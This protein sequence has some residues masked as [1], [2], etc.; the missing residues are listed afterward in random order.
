M[1]NCYKDAILEKYSEMNHNNIKQP[2]E[3][4]NIHVEDRCITNYDNITNSNNNDDTMKMK[5][6]IEKINNKDLLI[7]SLLEY[8]L[9]TNANYAQKIFMPAKNNN[10]TNNHWIILINICKYL[11]NIGIIDNDS[12][13]KTDTSHLRS[14]YINFMNSIINK[15]SIN[16]VTT[17]D[18]NNTI[19][20]PHRDIIKSVQNN[21]S[22]IV[23]TTDITNNTNRKCIRSDEYFNINDKK[24]ITNKRDIARQI[25]IKQLTQNYEFPPSSFEKSDESRN[26]G[27]HQRGALSRSYYPAQRCNEIMG[28]KCDEYLKSICIR[29][30]GTIVK[31][32]DQLNQSNQ[33]NQLD[34]LTQSVPTKLNNDIIIPNNYKINDTLIIDPRQTVYPICESNNES[35]VLISRY[36]NDFI[37]IEKIGEGGFGTVYKAYNKLDSNLYAVKKIPIKM[38]ENINNYIPLREVR[39][40]SQLNHP[41]IIRY[42]SAWIEIDMIDDANHSNLNSINFD[43]SISNSSISNN[44]VSNNS[45]SN[46]SVSNN[47]VSNNSVSNNSVSNNSVFNNSVSNNSVS[48]SS[49]SNNLSINSSCSSYNSNIDDNLTKKSD[50]L[51]TLSINSNFDL[52]YSSNI[53][54]NFNKTQHNNK[55]TIPI[56]YLQM[57][58]CDMSLRDYIDKRNYKSNKISISEEKNKFYQI[59]CGLKYI[60]SKNIIHRDLNPNNI[61]IQLNTNTVK[62]SDFGISVNGTVNDIYS[63]T[64]E[65]NEKIME[66]DNY[67]HKLYLA[68]EQINKKIC[69]KKSDIY[70]LGII[71]FELL[72]KFETYMER[73]TEIEKIKNNNSILS[74]LNLLKSESEII[75]SMLNIDDDNRPS[76]NDLINIVQSQSHSELH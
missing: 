67:G 30:D 43:D 33:L 2:F 25:E 41:N 49:I 39:Q 45:V 10:E 58:L 44:S 42:Y 56:I 59:L 61:L 48:N 71:Y 60:H 62:I 12:L 14:I 26:S 72:V 75:Q 16:S 21:T 36:N 18:T 66:N 57:E 1:T 15:Y 68:P 50:E 46:N 35:Y 34:Q 54:D 53:D 74:T 40:L 28:S 4:D 11:Y 76:A 13:Y 37:Q 32:L 8:I 65:N 52:S 9:T 22:S 20:I 51:N 64:E 3:P 17:S 63:A 27:L 31:R 73:I 29:N 47:S 5:L 55:L 19:N 6:L 24:N 38:I 23:F 70:S 69:S 7:I